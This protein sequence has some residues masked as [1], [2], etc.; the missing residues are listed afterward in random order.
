[1]PAV[2]VCRRDGVLGSSILTGRHHEVRFAAHCLRV[3]WKCILRAEFSY[4][5]SRCPVSVLRVLCGM[6][7]ARDPKFA[8]TVSVWQEP[9]ILAIKTGL[10]NA[11]AKDATASSSTSGASRSDSA[12]PTTSAAEYGGPAPANHGERHPEPGSAPVNLYL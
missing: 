5:N 7:S 11:P 2:A 4:E 9:M 3:Q 10:S 1:V 12:I 8:D 6:H